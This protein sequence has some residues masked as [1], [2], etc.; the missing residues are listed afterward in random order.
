[1]ELFTLLSAAATAAAVDYPLTPGCHRI[2]SAYG[3]DLHCIG[4]WARRGC[5]PL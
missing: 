2:S 3:S 5:S 4:I 1:M